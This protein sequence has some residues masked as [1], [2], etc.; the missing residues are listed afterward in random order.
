MLSH[1]RTQIDVEDVTLECDRTAL[2]TVCV[3]ARLHTR[4]EAA[5]EHRP[6]SAF[7]ALDPVHG[8]ATTRRRLLKH[9]KPL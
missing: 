4:K 1:T 9:Q 8:M 6:C 3:D 2:C 7:T 5:R